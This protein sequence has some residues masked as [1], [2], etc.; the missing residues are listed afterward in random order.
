MGEGGRHEKALCGSL[1]RAYPL[2][3]FGREGE[4]PY[5]KGDGT[6]HG[7]E[8]R[9]RSSPGCKRSNPPRGHHEEVGLHRPL[10]FSFFSKINS[11]R[12]HT[13]STVHAA[14]LLFVPL[15]APFRTQ[16]LDVHCL[17]RW[18]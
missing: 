10:S 8:G 6:R 14:L 16:H 7:K 9:Q 12:K 11:R 15:T 4:Q 3:P 13:S 5:K 1:R 18:T 2:K 17:S